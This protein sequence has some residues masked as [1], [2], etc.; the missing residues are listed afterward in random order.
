VWTIVTEDRASAIERRLRE[1]LQAVHVEVIDDSAL[2]ADH[3]GAQGGGG[4]F[5]V[6][7]VSPE[8]EGLTR[9]AA[10]RLVYEAVADLMTTDI[11]ALQMQTLTPRAWR[12]TSGSADDPA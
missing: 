4:H 9:V 1:R 5:R 7:V 2:H 6:L 11:H 10:Q 3:L 12:E 8:F